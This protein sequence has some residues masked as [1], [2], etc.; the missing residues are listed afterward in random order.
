MAAKKK[1]KRNEK[2]VFWGLRHWT[3]KMS[4]T[5]SR[6]MRNGVR[7][8]LPVHN[9]CAFSCQMQTHASSSR[10]IR[11]DP[12]FHSDATQVKTRKRKWRMK[13]K[14]LVR[15]SNSLRRLKEIPPATP[16]INQVSC[17]IYCFAFTAC[18]LAFHR[19]KKQTNKTIFL[20]AIHFAV[21]TKTTTK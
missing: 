20:V 14:N 21:T 6:R 7:C 11:N 13:E 16:A 12:V 10:L 9:S 19:A 5:P 17:L 2:I 3:T 4:P 15:Y 1:K 18:S 8:Q